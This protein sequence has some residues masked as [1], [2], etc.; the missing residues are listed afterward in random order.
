MKNIFFFVIFLGNLFFFVTC[1]LA[2]HNKTNIYYWKEGD[3]LQKIAERFGDNVLAIRQRNHIYETEDLFAGFALMIKTAKKPPS[4]TKRKPTS[5]KLR[6]TYPSLGSITSKYGNRGSKFHYGI[7][8]GSNKGKKITAAENG[9]VKRVGQ[10][11]GYGNVVE[12]SHNKNITSLYAHLEKALV[13]KGQRIKKKELLGV[14]GSTGRSTGVHL[15]FEI[16][17]N[18]VHLDP[19][20]VIQ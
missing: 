11:S 15:H 2:I 6:F 20:K 9:I 12:V 14:M 18:G 16:I 4:V 10:R 3:S 19:L 17:V 8:F 1:N 13:R 5:N 7:D